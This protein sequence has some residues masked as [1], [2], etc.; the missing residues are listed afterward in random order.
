M[1]LVRGVVIALTEANVTQLQSYKWPG[2]LR[3]L[4][5]LVERAL[6]LSQSGELHFDLPPDSATDVS[7]MASGASRSVGQIQS[8]ADLKRYEEANV[9]AALEKANWKIYGSGGAAE[10]LDVKPTTLISRMKA[11]GIKSPH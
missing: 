11:M 5:N 8:Y 3:E 6:I 2:N 1:A 9:L 4:Q 10:L 7:R